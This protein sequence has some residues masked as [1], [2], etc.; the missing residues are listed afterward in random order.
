MSSHALSNARLLFLVIVDA[1]DDSPLKMSIACYSISQDS[2]LTFQ[3]I[4]GKQAYWGL[5]LP[6]DL[7]GARRLIIRVWN[8]V[9]LEDARP[10]SN[11]RLS[12]FS[13]VKATTIQLGCLF[14]E[15][16]SISGPGKMVNRNFGDLGVYTFTPSGGSTTPLS[17]DHN[18]FYH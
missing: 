18:I 11:H 1:V 9:K 6:G 3:R 8:A 5:T 4:D 17:W 13:W 2:L 7:S 14:S 10:R 15:G 12:L 16:S